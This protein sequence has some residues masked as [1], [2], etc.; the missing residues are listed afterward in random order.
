[1]TKRTVRQQSKH[2]LAVECSAEYYEQEGYNVQADIEGYKSPKLINGKRP[3]IVATKKDDKVIVEVETEDSLE[4]DQKQLKV[5]KDYAG[6]HKNVRFWTKI[7][8]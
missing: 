5:F 3:D 6:S 4:T 7:A 8:K 1:M 2:D